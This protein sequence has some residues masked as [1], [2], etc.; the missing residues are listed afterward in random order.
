MIRK[1]TEKDKNIFIELM[2]EFYHSDGVQ[3]TLPKHYYEK[4]AEEVLKDSPYMT[5]YLIES[6]GGVAGYGQLSFTYST[7]AG[8]MVVWIEELYIRSK[9]RGRGLG[10]AFFDKIFT[11]Y[12][13]MAARF[14]LEIDPDNEG[15][16]RLY[17][18]LG[19]EN[20]GYE[21]MVIEKGC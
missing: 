3:H 6:E 11:M 13:N 2:D 7:E 8:G 20:L 9:F 14:R 4:A 1:I 5:A 12:Q 16:R 18:S 10:T 21:S 15:A 19:F 17:E